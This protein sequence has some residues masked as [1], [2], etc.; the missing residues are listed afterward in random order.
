[1]NLTLD[2]FRN[3]LGKV[4][5]GDV[6][7]KMRNGQKIGIEKAN[8]G[9]LLKRNVQNIPLE[10]NAA[11]R[12]LFADAISKA[13]GPYGPSISEE[14]LN[15]IKARLGIVEGA[16]P[17]L[18]TLTRPLDRREIKAI[19][20]IVDGSCE[21]IK[22]DNEIL[23]RMNAGVNLQKREQFAN[24]VNA[25]PLLSGTDDLKTLIP[26]RTFRG[27]KRSEVA[28]CVKENLALVKALRDSGEDFGALTRDSAAVI[29][30]IMHLGL[31]PFMKDDRT[32]AGGMF[33]C[34]MK[35]DG[36]RDNTFANCEA[37]IKQLQREIRR[38]RGLRRFS[39]PFSRPTGS[40]GGLAAQRTYRLTT[41][42]RRVLT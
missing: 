30:T 12:R 17:Q 32:V 14:T 33:M 15:S 21:Q 20:E 11:I 1:M 13:S 40:T 18:N 38:R 3:I 16:G 42:G 2:D 39:A 4:N 37:F 10:D 35:T 22:I 29:S 9:R 24:S 7:F 25:S 8:Y 36:V 31:T 26:G 5:D 19:L 28:K 41:N 27:F 23:G 6:V 34:M